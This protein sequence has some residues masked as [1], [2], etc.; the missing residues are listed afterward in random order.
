M[1]D[2]G[3]A[4]FMTQEAHSLLSS[5]EMKAQEKETQAPMAPCPAPDHP[6]VQNGFLQKIM[7]GLLG[8]QQTQN[9]SDIHVTNDL[10]NLND[11]TNEKD[12][13]TDIMA[14]SNF[15]PRTRNEMI[16]RVN[17]FDGKRVFEV[18]VPLADIQAV[19]IETPLPELIK[20]FADAGH[21][22]LPVYRDDLDDP[23]GMVHIK[24][25]MAMIAEER[26]GEGHKLE[27][28][29]RKVLYVP[30]SMRA[31]DLFLRMQASR[32]HMALVI[33]EY[34]GTDGLVTS[35]DLIEEIV[36]DINDEH[37]DDEGPLVVAAKSGG[38][39]ADARIDLDALSDA[40]KN[41]F[42]DEDEEVDTLGGLIVTLAGRVPMRGE[43]I[44]HSNGFEFVITDADTR[45]VR[46]IHIRPIVTKSIKDT[47]AKSVVT[48]NDMSNKNINSSGNG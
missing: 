39:N 28:I 19:D 26:I 31:I 45:K 1:A 36:G 7:G 5:Q 29:L 46:K 35:E 9:G 6:P 25:L 30:P 42:V 32:V 27:E 44:A 34:G 41:I 10:K 24:D 3:P 33:D 23:A 14:D 21:S 38:W 18:M 20:H 2:D 17:A 15:S 40:T 13:P 11:K 37:D 22:R 12:T 43:V 47:S 16:E 4:N 48:S 8:T